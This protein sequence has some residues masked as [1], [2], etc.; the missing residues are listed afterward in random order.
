MFEGK[1]IFALIIKYAFLSRQKF[2]LMKA[3]A[4]F[5]WKRQMTYLGFASEYLDLALAALST[6]FSELVFCLILEKKGQNLEL[7][8]SVFWN[9][10]VC[11]QK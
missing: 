10:L 7:P 1:K 2:T 8:K 5:S 9:N 6:E 4:S 11:A 3:G